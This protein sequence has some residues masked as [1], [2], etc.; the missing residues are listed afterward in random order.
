[1]GNIF[2]SGPFSIG[3][4]FYVK[5]VLQADVRVL[6]W[7]YSASSIGAFLGAVY[8][9]RMA[10]IRKRGWLGYA[11]FFLTGLVM[12][13]IGMLH[14]ISSSLVFVF[15]N[16]AAMS[17]FGMVWTNLLQDKMPNEK[18]GRVSSIDMLG[19]FALLPIG[20][21]LTGWLTDRIGTGGGVCHRRGG[22]D[23]P[24]SAGIAA[25]RHPRTGLILPK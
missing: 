15:I 19:S 11:T 22:V 21:G 16:G 4:P 25:S 17:V 5:D 20:Y 7:L 18:L 24:G 1:M 13:G 23:A 3:L 9:G 6:G 14:F 8:L 12:L 10:R 2:L